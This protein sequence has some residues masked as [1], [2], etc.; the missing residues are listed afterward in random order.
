MHD[1]PPSSSSDIPASLLWVLCPEEFAM[2]PEDIGTHGRRA[3]EV[4]RHSRQPGIQ[5]AARR[6]PLE[7]C[8][9]AVIGV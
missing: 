7:H 8:S 2:P 6:W 4:S 1:A 3:E 9:T 5:G